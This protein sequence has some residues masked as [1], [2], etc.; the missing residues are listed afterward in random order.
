MPDRKSA[1]APE[2]RPAPDHDGHYKL[3]FG[4]PVMARD[5]LR[6]FAPPEIAAALDF[7]TLKPLPTEF[8]DERTGRKRRGDSI[9]RIRKKDGSPCY[10]AILLEF[11]S[12]P[13]HYMAVRV[14][15]YSGLFLQFL[16][17]T[18][19]T[20]RRLGYPPLLPFVIYNG[21][22][23]WDAEEEVGNLFMPMGKELE[24]YS[25]RQRYVPVKVRALSEEELARGGMAAQVF[26]L[27][28]SAGPAE[29]RELVEDTI[30]NFAGEEYDNVRRLMAGWLRDVMIERLNITEEEVPVLE[31]LE[32]VSTMLAEN[33]DRWKEQYIQQGV[34]QGEVQGI[35]IG[36][37]RGGLNMLVSL[38]RDG[39][40][41]PADAA[42]RAN[43]SE[44][45]FLAR[46]REAEQSGRS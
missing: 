10:V 46:M 41:R 13:D 28:R 18:D 27:E 2:R 20:V 19:P 11:Q 43:M 24:P 21:P 25:P 17:R 7:G 37:A 12:R 44:E 16:A 22:V 6:A 9:W 38:A 45:E 23:D 14:W 1:P 39:L 5:L 40:L 31:S 15:V 33:L 29:M 4:D 30:A 8:I 42:A 26:R 34:A 32:G 36:E 35:R 3:M